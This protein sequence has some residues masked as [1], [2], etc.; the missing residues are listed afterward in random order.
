[1]ATKEEIRSAI[2]ELFTP[3]VPLTIEKTWAGGKKSIYSFRLSFDFNATSLVEKETGLS[4]LSGEVFDHPSTA[5]ISVLLWA[6]VQENHNEY[7]GPDGLR[8]IRKILNVVTAQQALS[9][10]NEA[11]LA[12]LPEEQVAL[13]KKRA[14]ERAAK[15]SG[16][17]GASVNPTEGSSSTA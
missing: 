14:E 9:A 12:A 2:D 4:M 11:F 10:I 17:A 15:A 1:M 13:L 6:G 16:K 5:T 7:E 8:M 3:S